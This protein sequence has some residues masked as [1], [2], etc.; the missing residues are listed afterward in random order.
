MFYAEVYFASPPWRVALTK[1]L[2]LVW[3]ERKEDGMPG[4][5]EQRAA[6]GRSM[7]PEVLASI[8]DRRGQIIGG[9]PQMMSQAEGVMAVRL[10]ELSAEVRELRAMLAPPSAVILTG[11]EVAEHFRRL[12]SYGA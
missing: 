9:G 2:G 11:A 3:P 4:F 7:P 5:D 6:Q 12:R 10:A 1:V 8:P